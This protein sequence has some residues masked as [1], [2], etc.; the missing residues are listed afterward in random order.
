MSVEETARQ[1][2]LAKQSALREDMVRDLA[3]GFESVIP[4]L[5]PEDILVIP[6]EARP[7]L[8]TS[9]GH[10]NS[11]ILLAKDTYVFAKRLSAEEREREL[12]CMNICHHSGINT[13]NPIIWSSHEGDGYLATELVNIVPISEIAINDAAQY[14][15]VARDFAH[16][17]TDLHINGIRHKD[18][19]PRNYAY[20]TENSPFVYDFGESEIHEAP[21]SLD[22]HR[23]ELRKFLEGLRLK[24]AAVASKHN[25]GEFWYR[26]LGDVIEINNRVI[27]D[28]CNKY[29]G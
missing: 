3:M 7:I 25:W 29:Q 22:A 4:T 9:K 8:K 11:Q 1:E 23:A 20:D 16:V 18:P 24:V 2:Y 13:L 6:Y 12:R 21:L 5:N 10:S 26:D 15:R 14:E 19:F 28:F 17:F 27:T